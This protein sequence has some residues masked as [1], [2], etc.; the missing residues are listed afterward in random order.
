[1]RP[2]RGRQGQPT[3][4][5]RAVQAIPRL[6]NGGGYSV[7]DAEN[8]RRD[9]ESRHGGGPDLG[10][11]DM[12]LW[13]VNSLSQRRVSQSQRY[14]TGP[15]SQPASRQHSPVPGGNAKQSA[16]TRQP[17]QARMTAAR[18]RLGESVPLGTPTARGPNA[19]P[20]RTHAQPGAEEGYAARTESCL[21]KYSRQLSGSTSSSAAR[22]RPSTSSRS[23]A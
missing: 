17:Q 2:L 3:L 11:D 22:C 12:G 18:P 6:L 8:H 19:S 21:R 13:R 23:R 9:V 4:A 1:M 16:R 14:A 7:K 20:F 5:L 10:G 15:C